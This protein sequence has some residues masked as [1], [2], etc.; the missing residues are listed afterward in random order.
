[1][2]RHLPLF[3]LSLAMTFP[4][5][6]EETPPPAEEA[7]NLQQPPR[8]RLFGRNDQRVYLHRNATRTAQP[9]EL[10][11]VEN[12]GMGSVFGGLASLVSSPDNITI[13]MPSSFATRSA[14][15]R[16]GLKG[17]PFFHEVALVPGQLIDASANFQGNRRCIPKSLAGTPQRNLR[18]LP[19]PSLQLTPEPGIDYEVSFGT[20]GSSCG[21]NARQLLADGSAVPLPTELLRARS[22]QTHKVEG[23]HLYTF[24][25]R[26]GSV[27]YRAVGE[28]ENL[29][30]QADDASHADAF[31]TAMR[32]LATRPGTRMCIVLPDFFYKSPLKDRLD[33]VLGEQGKD[34][35]AI[36]E[37]IEGMRSVLKIEA[38]VPT[39]FLAAVSYCQIAGLVAFGGNPPAPP[40][41]A[42][43]ATDVPDA[44]P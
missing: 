21:I 1:M 40:A 3:W 27:Y 14:N 26:P 17:K 29:Q 28:S 11:I 44:S 4:A 13:G 43:D 24:L 34:F 38:N 20:D 23:M 7:V 9:G 33:R 10:I 16:A 12:K 37:P 5:M 39:T 42:P 36:L 2:I 19:G 22:P 6:A 25:F 30:L 31:E 32:E 15:D 41:D 8:I 35:P 18:Y